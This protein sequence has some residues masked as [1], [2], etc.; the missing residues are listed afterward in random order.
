MAVKTEV[1]KRALVV[2]RGEQ[3]KRTIGT[4]TGCYCNAC[5]ECMQ[6]AIEAVEGDLKGGKD[7]GH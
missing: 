6:L 7:N 1:A 3:K 4:Y 5:V 2:F